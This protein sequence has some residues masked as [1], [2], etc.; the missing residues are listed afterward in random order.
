MANFSRALFV[1]WQDPVS[2]R[3]FPVGRLAQ[4]EGNGCAQCFEFAYVRAAKDE[5]TPAGFRPFN[6]FPDLHGLYRSQELFPMF[7]NRLLSP[8]REDY[9][10]YVQRLGL[11]AGDIGPIEILSRSGGRRETDT[12]ELFPMP[13]Q[14]GKIGYCTRFWIRSLR[15]L[16]EASRERADRLRPE[17][18]IY[19]M[20]DY[21]NPVDTGAIA[22]RTHDRVIVGYFPAY[23][24]EDATRL[25]SDCLEYAVF[26][27]QVNPSP[28]P[29]HQRVLCRLETCMP[30][31]FVPFATDRFEPLAEDAA[32]YNGPSAIPA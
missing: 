24:V 22:L 30:P 5:A 7:T 1:A 2:R 4:L 19:P 16:P 10:E 27:D 17:E 26:V 12:L 15:H 11:P 20:W 3:Y 18:E 21:K 28:A 6:A 32:Q 23:L 29:F 8:G 31:A 14:E 9:S 25:F 13:E